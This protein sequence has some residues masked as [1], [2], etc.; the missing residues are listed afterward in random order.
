MGIE[1]P[2]IDFKPVAPTVAFVTHAG[3]SSGRTADHAAWVQDIEERKART[4]AFEAKRQQHTPQEPKV[5][6]SAIDAAI[7]AA[8]AAL[9]AFENSSPR[10]YF[11][12]GN[13]HLSAGRR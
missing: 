13:S 4:A 12:G 7:E 6:L 2:N 10:M 11:A 9:T 8:D 1:Q 3:D 5:E